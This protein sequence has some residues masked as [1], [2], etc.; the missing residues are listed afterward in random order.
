[1]GSQ[2]FS[3]CSQIIS[4][5]SDMFCRR[6][7]KYEDLFRCFQDAIGSSQMG[8]SVGV[9]IYSHDSPCPICVRGGGLNYPQLPKTWKV[10]VSRHFWVFFCPMYRGSTWILMSRPLHSALGLDTVK[11]S[12]KFIEI[13]ESQMI[14]DVLRRS[15]DFLWYSDGSDGPGGSCGSDGLGRSGVGG[16]FPVSL[17]YA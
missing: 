1:M 15:Q 4:W 7:Q 8:R 16:R 5:C 12:L 11:Y 9:L 14:T 2:M 17:G 6:S 3:R 10:I 13:I